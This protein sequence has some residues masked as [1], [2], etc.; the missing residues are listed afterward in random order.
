MSRIMSF[1]FRS[2]FEECSFAE[3][4]TRHV[5]RVVP[6]SKCSENFSDSW[7]SSW[8]YVHGIVVVQRCAHWWSVVFACE[9]TLSSGI[10]QKLRT[11]RHLDVYW[12]LNLTGWTK[13]CSP[14]SVSAIVSWYLL[15]EEF[16][17]GIL[18]PDIHR[19]YALQ[20][21]PR[22]PSGLKTP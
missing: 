7:L 10:V 17:N 3:N 19:I 15:C 1:L 12:F 13:R 5:H 6:L 9:S 20:Q 21:V 14:Y 16:M 8:E 11:G 22:D 18:H 4:E 2:N